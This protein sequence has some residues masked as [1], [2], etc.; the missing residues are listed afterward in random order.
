VTHGNEIVYFGSYY[1]N[2]TSK[3]I[4]NYR[5]P[6]IQTCGTWYSYEPLHIDAEFFFF[7]YENVL[8]KKK[9]DYTRARFSTGVFLRFPLQIQTTRPYNSSA[10]I[11]AGQA[12]AHA[13]RYVRALSRLP[14]FMIVCMSFVPTVAL[15]WHPN[16]TEKKRKRRN[17]NCRSIEYFEVMFL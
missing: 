12:F 4:R 7:F 17:Y 3:L 5:S 1:P 10:P 9:Q 14:T 2:I 8:N 15:F 13:S 11:M 16:G 6:A